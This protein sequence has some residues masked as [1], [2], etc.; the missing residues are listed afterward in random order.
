MLPRAG[1]R[2]RAS[3]TLTPALRRVHSVWKNQYGVEP[4]MIETFSDRDR[5]KGD[6]REAANRT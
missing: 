3:H 6:R 1:I 2:N 5:N 4:S